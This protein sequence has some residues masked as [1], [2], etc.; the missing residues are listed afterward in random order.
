M[1]RWARSARQTT[2]R[3][4][5]MI[6]VTSL[7]A[8]LLFVACGGQRG[9]EFK[10]GLPGADDVKLNVPAKA[11]Q[12]LEAENLGTSRQALQ[13]QTSDFYRLPRG[14]TVGVNGGTAFVL[15]LVK[16]ITEYPAT[17][18]S[19][20]TA[21]WGP[22]TEALSPNTWK[23]S[24]TKVSDSEYSYKLE[25]KAKQ[26][27]DTA[28]VAVLTGTHP[29]ALDAAGNKLDHYGNGTFTLDWDKAST[30]PEHDGNVGTAAI[31]YGRLQPG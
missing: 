28:F 14:V 4:T 13:G 26:D 22:H 31:T 3:E 9:E 29:P 6:R 19:G 5:P 17:S 15:D 21:V 11:G 10:A 27:P 16:R 1:Q 25:G 12:A 2:E 8:A 24:V 20:N 23:L 30:L 7:S 18:V